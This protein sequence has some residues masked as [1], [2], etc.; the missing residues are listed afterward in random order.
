M[1][2][3]PGHGGTAIHIH[4]PKPPHSWSDLAREVG[5]IVVGILL[6]LGAEQIIE[7]LHWREQVA[8]AEDGIKSELGST[9]INAYE[10]IIV[11]PCLRGQIAVLAQRLDEPGDRWTAAPARVD[12]SQRHLV[13]T[14]AYL[15]PSRLWNRDFWQN[16][17][18]SGVISRFP[19]DKFTAF[20]DLYTNDGELA[21]LQAQEAAAAA[22]LSLLSRDRVLSRAERDEL[23]GVLANV[24][25]ING[26]M[27]LVASQI[28]DGLKDAHLRYD[29]AAVER[30]RREMVQHDRA[31]RGACV[32]DLPLDL[33]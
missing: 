3:V 11:Q 9:A 17:V 10:R 23:F 26:L 12:F 20:S 4:A 30:Y 28:I 13:I 6:A 29:K 14:P 32:A 7:R 24:D 1:A 2:V 22:R 33:G 15:P 16:A 25:R 19:A 5:V 8:I 31:I 27:A 21:D 18:T